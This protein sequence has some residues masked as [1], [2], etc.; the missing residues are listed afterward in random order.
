M[1]E[2]LIASLRKDYPE[3]LGV[4]KRTFEDENNRK[5]AKFI[6]EQQKGMPSLKPVGESLVTGEI[7]FSPSGFDSENMTP[8]YISKR[9][10]VAGKALDKSLMVLA[11]TALVNMH[12][13]RKGKYFALTNTGLN[14]I[15]EL[16]LCVM[17][18]Y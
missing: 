16:T 4:I 18:E 1:T 6:F 7:R 14:Y 2:S 12:Y 13:G 5:I 10:G 3:Y 9:T 11:Q 8:A 15:K 17:P